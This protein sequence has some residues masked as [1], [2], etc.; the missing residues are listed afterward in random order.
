MV[1]SSAST[2]SPIASTVDLST[3]TLSPIV[4]VL[5]DPATGGSFAQFMPDPEIISGELTI[6]VNGT[7]TDTPQTITF[8]A[9][10]ADFYFGKMRRQLASGCLLTVLYDGREVFSLNLG[11]ISS[12][13]VKYVTNVITPASTNTTIQFVETCVN[14]NIFPTLDM[15]N[16]AIILQTPGS[17]SS[18]STSVSTRIPMS[19]TITGTAINSMSTMT[20]SSLSTSSISTYMSTTS[21]MC[22]GTPRAITYTITETI[23]CMYAQGIQ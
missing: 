8:M 1:F 15:A 10:N 14:T 7:P 5:N 21:G 23:P 6:P 4:Q 16:I 17:S 12:T 11:A 22:N 3:A 20:S 13:Y 2:S 18:M 19:G 9:R